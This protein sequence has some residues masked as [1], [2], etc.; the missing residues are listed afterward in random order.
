[1]PAID[2]AEDQADG[3][4]TV[5]THNCPGCGRPGKLT[6]LDPV[7][8]TRWLDGEHIQD[9]MPELSASERELLISGMHGECWD[10]MFPPDED[11]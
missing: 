8:V 5:F 10:V 7:K 1:M 11:D 4:V 3:T 2:R 9:V 6:G